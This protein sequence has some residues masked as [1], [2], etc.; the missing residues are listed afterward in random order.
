MAS[1]DH[2]CE[3]CH[4]ALAQVW[5]WRVTDQREWQFCKHHAEAHMDVLLDANYVVA[6]DLRAEL[7]VDRLQGA[8]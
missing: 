8:L 4:A 3:R 1:N 2:A 5:F 6:R 7:V